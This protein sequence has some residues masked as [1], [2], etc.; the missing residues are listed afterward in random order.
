MQTCRR[1]YAPWQPFWRR[2]GPLEA[3]INIG[4]QQAR[5]VALQRVNTDHLYRLELIEIESG[6]ET[7]GV[8]TSVFDLLE[9][10]EMERERR[11]GRET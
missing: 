6:G 4:Y 8:T 5:H 1:R 2:I 3:F 11:G 7:P 9:L 10:V